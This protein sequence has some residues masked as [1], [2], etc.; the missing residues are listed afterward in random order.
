MS[1]KQVA[2]GLQ[3]LVE[4]CAD[5]ENEMVA[6]EEFEKV[7]VQSFAD[8][9]MLTNDNGFVMKFPDGSSIVLRFRSIGKRSKP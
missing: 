7:E 1:T 3:N 6:E 9:G 2:Y 5:N 4:Q 8:F